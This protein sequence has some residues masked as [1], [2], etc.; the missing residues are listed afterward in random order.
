MTADK[1]FWYKNSFT[2]RGRIFYPELFVPKPSES[3]RLQYKVMFAWPMTGQEAVMQ[4]INAFLMEAKQKNW[5]TFPDHAFVKPIKRFDTY[6]R[7]DGRPNHAFLN[8]CYWVNAAS[9]EQFPP[10]IVRQDQ[11]PITQLDQ[12]EVYS[13]RNA[14]FNF[15]FYGYSNP[16]G[17]TGIGVN[18]GAIMLLEGGDVVQTGGGVNLEDAFGGF[19]AD[20]GA[21]VQGPA[22]GQQQQWNQPPQQQW[23]QPPQQNGGGYNPQG[24]QHYQQQNWNGQHAAPPTNAPNNYQAQPDQGQ[25][26]WGQQWNPN[27]NPF[28]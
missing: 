13:G 2:L 7:Q 27:Q 14:L 15:T 28:S 10:T 24:G 9:G 4:K 11:S 21:K 25:Q 16:K 1:D 23:N 5:P 6:V 26:H 20:M 18:I 19:Q 22:Q 17:K 3:G 8:G 12:A